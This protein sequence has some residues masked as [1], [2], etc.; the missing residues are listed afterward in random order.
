MAPLLA[1][2]DVRG[3]AQAIRNLLVYEGVEFEDK[4]YQHG[5]PPEHGRGE[6]LKDKFNLGLKFPNLPYYMDDDV[7]ITQSL[8]ILRYLAR[9]YDLNARNDVEATELDVLEQQAQDLC[10]IL[11]YEAVPMPRYR[12]G[13]KS[14]A[15]NV[16]DVLRPWAKHLA[17]LKW[18][19]GERLTY[20]DFLLYE[21]LDWHRVKQ[22]FAADLLRKEK[23]DTSFRVSEAWL[24]AAV[25][26][27]QVMAP[28]L[29]YWNV[30]GLAQP[31]R[32]L[33]VYK[34]VSFE[35][36]QYKFGPPPDYDL[37]VWHKGEKYK[38]GLTFPNLPYYIDGD[39]KLTQ[40]L[41]ILRYLGRK[42]DLAARNEREMTELDVIEQQARDLCLT[43]INAAA[44]NPTAEHGLES[45]VEK[46]SQILR[47]WDDFLASRKWTMGDRLTYVDFLLYEG[48][49]WHR[50]FKPSVV[51][52]YQNIVDYLKRFEKL[53]N[54]E[55]YF[56]SDRYIKWPILGPFR[57]WGYRKSSK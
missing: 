51:Q 30:R 50:E 10:L 12:E 2:W 19:L 1:Y 52:G 40:S 5:P 34:G 32:N 56:A 37:S 44:P 22:S 28:V 3:F 9:K 23:I 14:Y 43:L 49:D 46:M 7:K 39:V 38:L 41:A 27:Y 26:W 36:K 16:A 33:L 4:R 55:E 53:P 25:I 8:A 24:G 15:E 45:Y 57:M 48:L 35:D 17:G 20:V 21:G 6:W 11:A 54:M 47:S 18:A 13:L 42:H 31:I 29:G